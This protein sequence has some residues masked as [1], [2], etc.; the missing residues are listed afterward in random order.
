MR[1][2]ISALFF[3]GLVTNVSAAPGHGEPAVGTYL[4]TPPEAYEAGENRLPFAGS[5][6]IFANFDGE[7]LNC[8][9]NYQD[10]SRTN[11]SWVCGA[12]AGAGP[13]NYAAYNGSYAQ[14]Q[15]VIDATKEDWAPFDVK[16]VTERP[17]SGDYTMAMVGPSN[18][19]G[20]SVLGVAPLDCNDGWKN[21]V[22]FAF[23][24]SQ[25]SA[26]TAAT[27]I[28]QEVAHAYGL[29]HVN[30]QSD[31]MNP[32]AGHGNQQF[33][34]QC[35]SIV[36]GGSCAAQHAQNCGGGQQNSFKDLINLFGPASPDNED[37]NVNITAPTDGEVFEVGADFTIVAEASDDS[38]IAAVELHVDGEF[39]SADTQAPY[40][41]PVVGIPE[42]EHEFYAVA[43]DEAGNSTISP[44][45]TVHA[46]EDGEDSGG[47]GDDGGDGDGD[48]GDDG[49]DAGDGDGG[50]EGEWYPPGALPPGYGGEDP[51]VGC[52]CTTNAS[53]T[54]AWWLALLL[55]PLAGRRRR[56]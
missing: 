25:H 6:T 49:D 19:I 9:S 26:D 33:L 7:V 32:S 21:N 35:T 42:G 13:F 52:G 56:V 4:E 31:I 48:D 11:T 12:Y 18:F 24:G 16:V 27:T 14:K 50:D 47:D 15:A 43:E 39:I 41:W 30:N 20:G 23:N 54:Q 1:I 40:E 2:G 5:T 22:V 37:P 38:A 29:E 44:V 34:D 10:D 17:Q 53:G 28:S 3:C 36:A 8:V 55:L 45:I 46:T 51:E